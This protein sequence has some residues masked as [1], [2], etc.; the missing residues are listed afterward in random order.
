[1]GTTQDDGIG[2]RLTFNI[3]AAC[4][5]MG[6]SRSTLYRL[7]AAD[8]LETRKIFGRTLVTA[9]SIRRKLR[10]DAPLPGGDAAP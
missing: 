9:R 1:M 5:V 2:G 3:R 10:L 8:E 6:I 4:E 7:I